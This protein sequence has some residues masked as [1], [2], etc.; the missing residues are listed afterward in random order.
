MNRFKDAEHLLRVAGVF[1]IGVTA[2]LLFRAW[3]VPPS[4][5]QY[6]HYR[7]DSMK[8]VAALPVVHAGHE[9]CESCHSDVLDVKKAG[10]H[11][12]VNCEA[13]HGPQGKHAED[14]GSV[15]PVLPDTS[16]LCARC[17]EANSAKPKGFPAVVTAEHSMGMPCNTCHKPHSPKIVDDAAAK[18]GKK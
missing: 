5:G 2:F 16:V 14:P 9:V 13:C 17:H 4:F 1:L 10:K 8:D 15:K 11:A 18:G 12:G 3:F 6:G 7:A